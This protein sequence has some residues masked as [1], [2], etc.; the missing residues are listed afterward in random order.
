[1]ID[2]DAARAEAEVQGQPSRITFGELRD[3][4][5]KAAAGE[6]LTP[7]EKAALEHFRKLAEAAAA[8]IGSAFKN[9]AI[10]A[11]D[12]M[13]DPDKRT[14]EQ[15]K[16][17]VRQYIQACRR[18][19]AVFTLQQYVQ[20]DIGRITVTVVNPTERTLE[21]VRIEVTLPGTVTAHVADELDNPDDLI[22]STPLPFGTRTAKATWSASPGYT[23][24]I[25]GPV[26]SPRLRTGPEI[27]NSASTK[28]TFAPVTLRPHETASLDEVHLVIEKPAGQKAIEG[29]WR[30][31]ATNADGI[32]DGRLSLGL[33]TTPL[34]VRDMLKR[35]FD[36]GG[37]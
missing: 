15:Y 18:Y 28:V 33:S 21:N 8:S 7:T 19:F 13:S 36:P 5:A 37:E 6:D 17:E 24:L 34:P 27:S 3:V 25:S 10:R 20:S 29:S 9:S 1:M 14:P 16:D 2:L 32:V 22:P 4:E 30:A 26:T 23:N 12:L 11:Q 31:T 35:A